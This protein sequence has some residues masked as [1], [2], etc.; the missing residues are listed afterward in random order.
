M[1]Y[2]D[3]QSEHG[4]KLIEWPNA[5]ANDQAWTYSD[6]GRCAGAPSSTDR[7]GIARQMEKKTLEEDD[8]PSANFTVIWRSLVQ[9]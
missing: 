5:V 6:K 2:G 3:K 4:G 1:I 7:M 8:C 9:S